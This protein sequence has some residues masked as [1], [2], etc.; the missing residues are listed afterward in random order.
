MTRGC[1]TKAGASCN[2]GGRTS[3]AVLKKVAGRTPMPSWPVWPHRPEPRCVWLARLSGS[4]RISTL[5]NNADTETG[6]AP[7]VPT[8]PKH[9]I[10]VMSISPSLA[11]AYQL[12]EHARREQR[13]PARRLLLGFTRKLAAG[14]TPPCTT[15]PEATCPSQAQTITCDRLG[16][17]LLGSCGTRCR[18]EGGENLGRSPVNCSDGRTCK[19]R[20]RILASLHP[21]SWDGGSLTDMRFYTRLASGPSRA[22]YKH[23][24]TIITP[25]AA[26]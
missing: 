24:S 14:P 21:A 19:S 10:Y 18:V 1:W 9:S 13:Q 17:R 11:H 26:R 5:G 4:A 20:L 25:C 15:L 7:V 2:E 23:V 8:N 3:A 6:T 16:W 22:D 12:P